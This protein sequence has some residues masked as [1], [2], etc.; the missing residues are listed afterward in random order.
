M[1]C[2]KCNKPVEGE[3]GT[4]CSLCAT[5]YRDQWQKSRRKS[6]LER[7]GRQLKAFHDTAARQLAPLFR[8][9]SSP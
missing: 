4:W 7:E 5:I 2:P 9:F 3:A 8:E 1:S 6:L